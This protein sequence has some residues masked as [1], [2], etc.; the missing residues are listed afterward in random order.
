MKQL[1]S[2][3]I[4][5][6]FLAN[7]SVGQN[8]PNTKAIIKK[9][10]DHFMFQIGSESWGNAPDSI[11]TEM[12]GFNKSFNVAIMLNKPFKS[13][14]KFSLAYGVGIGTSNVFFNK[15][16]VDIGA[17]GTKL[18]FVNTTNTN[19]YKKY[20]LSYA[21]VEVPLELRFNQLG[22]NTNKGLKAA[23]GL[24]LGALVNAHT[25]GK[26]L[27][28]SA[29]QAV[30]SNIDKVV[31]RKFFNSSRIAAT[32]RVGLGVFSIYG[33]YQLGNLFKDGVAAPIKPMQIGICIAGF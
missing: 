4:L 31:T 21:Y 23:L 16:N 32:A 19:N 8:M 18:N 25:K 3:I 22:D 20:K 28:N 24:K 33:Q 13:N 14:P 12:R 6:A 11:K 1:F 10:G 27:Q 15:T 5:V 7:T 26:D 17:T 30:N 2:A 29:G 9:A